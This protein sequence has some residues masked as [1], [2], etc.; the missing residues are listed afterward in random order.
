MLRALLLLCCLQSALLKDV[1]DPSWCVIDLSCAECTPDNM[2]LV[3]SARAADGT[4]RAAPGDELALS[5]GAGR[6]AAYPLRA[7]LTVRCDAGRYRVAHDAALLSLLDLGC[8]E[9][10]YEDVQHSVEHCGPPLQGRS[11]QLRAGGGARHLAAMCYDADRALPVFARVSSAGTLQLAPHADARAPLSLLGNFDQ[12][13]DAGTRHAAE[14]LFADDAGLARRLREIMRPERFDFAGQ[15]L[16]AGRLLSPLYFDDQDVRVAEFASN[17]MAVWRSVA[18]GNLAHLQADVA[19]LL[20]GARRAGR[21]VDVYA[22]TSGAG[23][24]R[25]AGGRRALRLRGARFPVPRYV[26]AVVV[27]RAAGRS[28]AV[29]VLNDPFVAVS[30]VRE[31]VFCDSLCGRAGWLRELRRLRGYEVPLYGL[32]FCCSL[33]NFTV[34][35]LPSALL[36]HVRPGAEGLLTDFYT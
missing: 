34:P 13:F 1:E 7:D 5:C 15:K 12:M 20:R 35:E 24:L 4:V 16:T 30:E 31:A 9:N 8:Q 32:A 25:A 33:H 6:F 10:V 21:A 29:A 27:D 36:Q 28:L 14:R 22:G 17:K 19:A 23:A 18:E 3:T 26:W 2:P 11:Y